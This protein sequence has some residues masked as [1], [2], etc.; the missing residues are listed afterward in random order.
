MSPTF[1]TAPLGVINA[2]YSGAQPVELGASEE[3]ILA[4]RKRMLKELGVAGLSDVSALSG[5]YMAGFLTTVPA[6]RLL[7]ANLVYT[8]KVIR[9]RAAGLGFSQKQLELD[10]ADLALTANLL[11]MSRRDA[12]QW[13]KK[14]IEGALSKNTSNTKLQALRSAAVEVLSEVP[15]D[16]AGVQAAL[17]P[18]AGTLDSA[19][20]GKTWN[21]GKNSYKI[22][23]AGTVATGN[24][25]FKKGDAKYAA[26]VSNLNKDL[27]SGSLKSGAAPARRS[28]TAPAELP[29]VPETAAVSSPGLQTSSVTDAW[30][31]WPSV[32]VSTLAVAGGV[33]WVFLRKKE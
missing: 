5:E 8:G 22:D 23:A 28:Y 21:D 19:L 18:A 30:W 13:A 10:T 20:L 14:Q 27:A 11:A 6:A 17:P 29:T 2:V 4:Y 1:K 25:T 12:I 16:D 26:V 32:G 3:D 7:A 9:A 15:A 33:Y 31:F 24:K